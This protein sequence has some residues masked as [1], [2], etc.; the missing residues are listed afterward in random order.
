MPRLYLGVCPRGSEPPAGHLM[1]A[2][3]PAQVLFGVA[4]H[5]DRSVML[6]NR[7]GSEARAPTRERESER[8]VAVFQQHAAP[9]AANGLQ[10]AQTIGAV[11]AEG[12]AREG[13]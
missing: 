4:A 5:G 12:G 13:G 6:G 2:A 10:R 9:E 3:V 11:G 1:K 8:E 7:G